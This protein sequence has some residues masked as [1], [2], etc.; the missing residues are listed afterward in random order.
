VQR[1]D[2][3]ACLLLAPA[4]EER[5]MGT[6]LK[7][8]TDVVSFLEE[9][10]EQV[11]VLFDEVLAKQGE[12]RAKAFFALRRMLAVH[13]TAE[14]EILHP[15]ARRALPAGERIVAARLEEEKQAKTMLVLLESLAL[16]SPEFEARFADFRAAVLAHAE[17]EETDEFSR[18]RVALRPA[19]L[20]RM[21][22]VVELAEKLAPTRPHPGVESA[23]ANLLAGPLSSIL[24]RTR[25]AI[26]GKSGS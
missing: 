7:G 9:Q 16:D 18:L 10:H 15:V 24:D 21:K 22:T 23:T 6:M 13:E 11:K 20:E 1:I 14:E 12:A 4:P 3:E 8:G 25:D 17:A 2:L 5:T 19:R 26:A